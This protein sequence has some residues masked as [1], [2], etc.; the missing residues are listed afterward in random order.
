MPFLIMLSSYIVGTFLPAIW[1]ENKHGTSIRT[2]GS[3]N[4]G[5]RNVGRVFGKK[6]FLLVFAIDFGKGAFVV[7]AAHLI[8]GRPSILLLALVAVMVGHCYPI[9]YR[10]QGGKGA[11]SFIGGLLV[12]HASLLIAIMLCFFLLYLLIKKFTAASVLATLSIIPYTLLVYG[13]NTA[14]P[15]F[16]IVLLLL[17]THRADLHFSAE[18]S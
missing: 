5:A 14:I 10:F 6:A 8:D 18:R 3:G 7:Y 11:A 17:W 2:Q 16:G 15:A 9:V 4:P 13:A 1:F 12:F